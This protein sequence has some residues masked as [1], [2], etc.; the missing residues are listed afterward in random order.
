MAETIKSSGDITI[1]PN[2]GTGTTTFAP[3][4]TVDMTGCTQVGI[5]GVFGEYVNVFSAVDITPQLN[6]TSINSMPRGVGIYYT[7]SAGNHRF[8]FNITFSCTASSAT[9]HNFSIAGVTFKSGAFNFQPV[10]PRMATGGQS[11][12]HTEPGLAEIRVLHASSQSGGNWGFSG[13]VELDSKPTWA[14]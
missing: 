9:Q 12:A 10:A 5:G 11:E 2:S 8:K 3:G 1:D 6:M 4:S 14:P 7:D 13:D